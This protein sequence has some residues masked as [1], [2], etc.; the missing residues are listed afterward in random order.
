[1]SSLKSLKDRLERV[2]QTPSHVDSVRASVLALGSVSFCKV[3]ENRTGD[4]DSA[5][6]PLVH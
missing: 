2:I 1:M 5:G 4:I 6:R 3:Y